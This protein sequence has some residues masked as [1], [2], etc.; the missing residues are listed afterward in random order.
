MQGVKGFFEVFER[1]KVLMPD[2]GHDFF[3]RSF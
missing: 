1:A 2:Y 3:R